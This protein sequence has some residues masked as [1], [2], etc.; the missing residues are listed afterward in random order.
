M[1]PTMK[2]ATSITLDA[3]LHTRFRAHARDAGYSVSSLIEAMIMVELGSPTVSP[4]P[5]EQTIRLTSMERRLLEVM[6]GRSGGYWTISDLYGERV[7][8]KPIVARCLMAL[9][10]AGC[11][12]RYGNDQLGKAGIGTWAVKPWRD[13]LREAGQE[14]ALAHPPEGDGDAAYVALSACKALLKGLAFEDLAEGERVLAEA[15]GFEPGSLLGGVVTLD[16]TV[17]PAPVGG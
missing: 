13:V 17:R 16:R 15:T 6:R 12:Y 14:F 9:H 10:R 3:D 11:V 4:R 2:I 5:E 8:S 7:A 1:F